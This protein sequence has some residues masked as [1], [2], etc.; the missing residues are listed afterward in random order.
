MKL[1]AVT[2]A[3]R[4]T[5]ARLNDGGLWVHS[6]TKLSPELKAEVDAL[7]RVDAVLAPSNGHNLWLQAWD[8]AYPQ[9]TTYVSRGIPKKLPALTSYRFIDEEADAV[10]AHDLV[11]F[12][13]RGV[14]FFD[15]CVFLHRPSGSLIVTDFVQ[16]HRGQEHTGFAKVMT[17]L[18]LEP[19][20]F[21]DIC[22]APPL[23]FKLMVKDRPAFI[24]F[25]K[26][27]Q[28]ENFDRIIVAHG[29]II[30]H[31]ARATLV[32]LCQRFNRE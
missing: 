3:L 25:V 9:A 32:R 8:N 30:E 5:I 11:L 24:Q 28:A 18:I 23:R 13:M 10:W 22:L 26:A 20:G 16:N 1:A 2:L 12:V 14:P 31:D 19:V 7:G 27:V 6:P 15:E 4:M 17:K 21:K 29:D